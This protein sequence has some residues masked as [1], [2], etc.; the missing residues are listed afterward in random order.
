MPR[1]VLLE[2]EIVTLIAGCSRLS[3]DCEGTLATEY[4]KSGHIR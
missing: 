3:L 1:E 2:E 4:V